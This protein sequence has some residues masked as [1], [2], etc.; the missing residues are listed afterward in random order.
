MHEPIQDGLEAYL[1][2]RLSTAERH[3]FLGHLAECSGCR[4]EVEALREHAEMMRLLRAPEQFDPAPGF[5]ARVMERIEAQTVPSLW[6]IFLE[7]AF[8]GRLLVA[9]LSLF[10]VLAGAAWRAPS[11]PVVLGEHNP[12]TVLATYEMQ[13]ASGEDPQRDREVVFANLASYASGSDSASLL[14]VASE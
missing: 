11:R 5:Y 2:G 8:G 7:P 1:S 10:A 12:V 3:R 4:L 13:P 9:A 6:S 14:P